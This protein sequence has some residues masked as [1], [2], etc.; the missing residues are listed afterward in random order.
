M[1]EAAAR[2]G[3]ARRISKM[4]WRNESGDGE[5]MAAMEYPTSGSG[6]MEETEGPGAEGSG[7]RMRTG[8]RAPRQ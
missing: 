7:S 5:A 2:H 4:R 6:E 8:P 3:L 1:R